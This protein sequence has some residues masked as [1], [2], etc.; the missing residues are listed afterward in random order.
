M[1]NFK[2]LRYETKN[3]D[4]KKKVEDMMTSKLA[5]Q[6]YSP[7]QLAQQIPNELMG[8]TEPR[9]ENPRKTEKDI[10]EQ[11]LRYLMSSLSDKEVK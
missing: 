4:E 2:S 8:R 1:E 9:W 3:A 11:T 6:I 5:K 10:F 7:D